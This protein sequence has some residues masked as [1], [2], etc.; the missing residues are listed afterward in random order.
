MLRNLFLGCFSCGRGV[1][2]LEIGYTVT[3]KFLYLQFVTEKNNRVILNNISSISNEQ[4]IS[5]LQVI[6]P[7]G[8]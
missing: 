6:E 5:Y 7:A 4:K 1:V 3:Q 2:F 8:N